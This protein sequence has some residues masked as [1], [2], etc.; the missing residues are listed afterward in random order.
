MVGVRWVGAATKQLPGGHALGKAHAG[1]AHPVFHDAH[2][3]AHLREHGLNGRRPVGF[4]VPKP[5][6]AQQMALSGAES[7]QHRHHGEEVRTVVQVGLKSAQRCPAHLDGAGRSVQLRHTGPGFHQDVQDGDIGLKALGIKPFHLNFAKDGPG[8]QEG[9]RTGPIGLDGKMGGLVTLSSAEEE[10]HTAAKAPVLRFQEGIVALHF[11][12]DGNAKLLE[13]VHRDEK[14]GDTA[15]LM[16][17]QGRFSFGQRQGCQEAAHQLRAAFSGDVGPSGDERAG[18]LQRQRAVRLA[19]AFPLRVQPHAVRRHDVM[20]IGEG[21]FQQRFFAR[22]PH[23]LRA[24]DRQQ[25]NAHA[26][27]ETGFPGVEFLQMQATGPGR[28]ALN[29]E[30]TS[31]QR[32]LGSQG[33]GG[34]ECT[35]VVSTRGIAFQGGNAI[36]QGCRH[37]GPLRKAL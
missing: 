9:C 25:R 22:H 21:P 7:R 31:F 10:V 20:G 14:V 29:A 18:H 30:R 36:G 37:D 24:Q 27:E 34:T 5:F 1:N 19:G 4:F 23:G 17:I 2:R 8:H 26:R 32:H 16:H 11:R 33:P 35:L 3:N 13:Y 12:A 6:H 15:R 28:D